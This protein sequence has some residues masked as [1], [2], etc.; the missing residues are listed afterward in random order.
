M[1]VLILILLFLAGCSRDFDNPYLPTSSDYAGAD[2]SLD[3]D[4]NGVADSVEKYAPECQGDPGG[5]LERAR[6]RFRTVTAKPV[7]D[8]STPDTGGGKPI[9][10]ESISAPDLRLTVGEMRPAQVELLPVEAT[11]RT[12]EL[13][14]RNGDVAVVKPGG[15]YAAGVGTASITVHALDGSGKTG[16]FRV[17]VNAPPGRVESLKAEDM[18]FS[19]LNLLEPKRKAP[20]L[21]WKPEDAADKRYTL[22]SDDPEVARIVG[23]SVEAVGTGKAKVTVLSLDGGKKAVFTVEV[24]LLD[25]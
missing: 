10:V 14:S 15:I 18:A 20:S 7:A 24:E 9:L 3:R 23:D 19:L 1:G 17:I 6:D 25:L 11:S 13:S 12:Y 22:A 21:A 5:C 4:G 16:E 2:W 8:T